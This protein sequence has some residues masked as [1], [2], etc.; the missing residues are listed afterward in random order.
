[1]FRRRRD[2][3]ASRAVPL[4]LGLLRR[5]PRLRVALSAPDD[6]AAVVVLGVVAPLELHDPA[7][8]VALACRRRVEAERVSDLLIAAQGRARAQPVRTPALDGLP[9]IA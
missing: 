6:H 4:R 3:A 7:R 2:R 1:M 9:R 5:V 8:D